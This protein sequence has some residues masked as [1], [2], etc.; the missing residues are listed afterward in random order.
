MG[1]RN[2]VNP[3]D[4]WEFM[5]YRLFRFGL[6]MVVMAA[7]FILYYLGFFGTYDGP[8]NPRNL[9][10][11]LDAHGVARAHVAW[12]FLALF[13]LLLT[14]NWILNLVSLLRG[15]RLVCQVFDEQGRACG[16]RV[17]REKRIDSTGKKSI[18]FACVN[19]HVSASA[20]FRPVKKGPWT[21]CLCM[22]VALISGMCIYWI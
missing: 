13:V 21:Y 3:A 17:F 9:G 16:A 22:A 12:F 5:R 6:S 7:C 4:Q 20:R 2:S 19:G 1:G 15:R 14:W 11:I 18:R 8:L 10:R